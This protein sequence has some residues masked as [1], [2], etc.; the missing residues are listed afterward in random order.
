MNSKV[1][2]LLTRV[3]RLPRAGFNHH[4]VRAKLSKIYQTKS[5]H[6]SFDYKLRLK[7]LSAKSAI[8]LLKTYVCVA[9]QQK[10]LADLRLRSRTC[11]LWQQV[12]F[13]DY[14]LPFILT[15]FHVL[16]GIHISSRFGRTSTNCSC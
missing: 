7:G 11:Y 15:Y 1:R 8:A 12:T 4:A 14:M 3:S 2:K 13:K 6:K 10:K 9:V 16:F 5:S